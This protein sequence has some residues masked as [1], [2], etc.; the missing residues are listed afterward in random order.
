MYDITS[1][2]SF[3]QLAKWI[4]YVQSVRQYGGYLRAEYFGKEGDQMKVKLKYV[5]SQ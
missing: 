3:N 1:L 5:C 4:G 2:D